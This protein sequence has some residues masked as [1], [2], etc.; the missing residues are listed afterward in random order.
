[1]TKTQAQSA[2]GIYQAF[3]EAIR[4]LK[5]VPSG[6]LYARLMPYMSLESYNKVLE[7]LKRTG[8]IKVSGYHLITWNIQ[9]EAK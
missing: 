2:I 9:E 7:D 8:I 6:E 1:M 4:E 3:A 5:S